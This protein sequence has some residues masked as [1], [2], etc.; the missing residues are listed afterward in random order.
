MSRKVEIAA[1]RHRRAVGLLDR[2][3][4]GEIG[5]LHRLARGLGRPRDVAA[6]ALAHLDQ[7]AQRP[8][9][10]GQLL[11]QADDV[12]ARPHLVDLRALGLLG[13][14]QPVDA[15]QRHPPVVADDAAAAIGIG[16]AGDD[17]ADAGSA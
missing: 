15:V 2:A 3:E 4:I 7:V 9:L 1:D 12:L 10:L 16:Q 8:H 14:E 13:L 5:P 6:V 11:A 17:V